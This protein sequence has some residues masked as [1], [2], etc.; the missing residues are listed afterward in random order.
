MKSTASSAGSPLYDAVI[1][2]T[3]SSVRSLPAKPLRFAF[4]GMKPQ[5]VVM[6]ISRLASA[7]EVPAFEAY[8]MVIFCS[9]PVNSRVV[10]DVVSVSICLPRD[11]PEEC[12]SLAK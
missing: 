7:S 2:T 3:G 6:D 11:W 5:A 12:N 10:L 1:S 8:K 4:R 9:M